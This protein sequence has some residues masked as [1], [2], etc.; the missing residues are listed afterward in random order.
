MTKGEAKDEYREVGENIRHWQQ[1]RFVAMTVFMAVTAGLLAALFQWKTNLTTVANTSIRVMGMLSVIVFWIQDERIVQYWQHYSNRA[2]TLE[3]ELS[4]QQYS[5]TPRR[6]KIVTSGNAIRLLY[7]AF[8]VFWIST[9]V[10][11][12]QF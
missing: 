5:T 11:Y 4:F 1:M 12:F 7:F 10:F 9:L 8:L 3:E 6:N 2:K